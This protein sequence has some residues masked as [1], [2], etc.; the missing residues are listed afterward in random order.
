MRGYPPIAPYIKK[1]KYIY[2][3]I[4]LHIWERLSYAQGCWDHT[5]A[6][7]LISS[8]VSNGFPSLS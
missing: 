2:I 7:A 4:Y 6:S 5:A 1:T 3:Y 8:G